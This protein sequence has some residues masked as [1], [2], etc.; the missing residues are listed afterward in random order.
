MTIT[1]CE[2]REHLR[3]VPRVTCKPL[4]DRELD[5]PMNDSTITDPLFRAERG[6]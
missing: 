4:T 6:W 1:G 2:G 5:E 3:N